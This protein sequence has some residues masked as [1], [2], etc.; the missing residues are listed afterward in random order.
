MTAQSNAYVSF[1]D[2]TKDREVATIGTNTG[3]TTLAF[4]GWRKFKEAFA[5]EVVQRAVLETGASLRRPVETCTDPFGGSGTTALACQ[6]LGV[7]PTTIEVNP[8]LADLIE[9]KLTLVDVR[10]AARSFARLLDSAPATD[11]TLHFAGAPQTFVEPGS[12]GKFLFTSDVAQR[13]SDLY[14]GIC[15]MADIALSRLCR[16]LLASAVLEV[17]NATVSGKGRRY[18]RGWERSHF[19]A[20]DL[21]QALIRLFSAAIFDINRYDRRATLD[22]NILRGD[23]RSLLPKAG[24]TDVIIF[25]PPY[26]NSFDYTDVYNIELWCARYLSTAAD[27]SSL[28]K[29]T[30]RSHV[31]IKRDFSFEAVASPSLAP[32]LEALGSVKNDLWN[33]NIPD[34]VGAYCADMQ[35]IMEV[36]TN[37][38]VGGGQ[39]YMI[40]GDSQYA[41]VQVPV[42]TILSEIGSSLNLQVVKSEPFR[43]MRAS[44]QQGGRPELAETL[45]V[46][47][48]PHRAI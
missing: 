35:G 25:S 42:G 27:N 39:L 24:R 15:D 10:S 47:R 2:W 17:C 16:V 33:K 48:K 30:I 7:L 14:A 11:P 44:P 18:R 5:P 32:V 31:Q 4:Q 40:V 21:D 9:A 19:K 8:Y 43:S 12:N 6:F 36:S 37:N 45:I 29:S 3:S 22:F 34:M 38:L 28:R 23:A 46:L 41:G 26:P 1:R 20:I 13:I